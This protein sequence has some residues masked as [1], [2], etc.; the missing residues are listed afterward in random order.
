MAPAFTYT[1]FKSVKGADGSFNLTVLPRE[2]SFPE[3]IMK[4]NLEVQF[5]GS[6]LPTSVTLNG[7]LLEFSKENKENTWNYDGAELTVQIRT[8]PIDCSQKTVINIQFPLQKADINGV[9]GKMNR[10]RKAVSLL[11]NNW[12][13]G[14]PIPDMISSTNQLNVRLNYKPSDFNA[15]INDFNKHYLQIGDTIGNT[16]VDKKVVSQC[17]IYLG[18]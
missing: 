10:L 1:T 3:M 14:A 5:Y 17:L 6:V 18:K 12:F 8:A 15:L 13:D 11:K 16:H 7:T 4:R 2:G 9:I